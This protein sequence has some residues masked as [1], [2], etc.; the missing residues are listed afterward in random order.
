MEVNVRMMTIPQVARTGLLS[1]STL[2]KMDRQ[3][4]LPTIKVNKRVYVNY[5]KLVEMLNDLQGGSANG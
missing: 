4:Q 2:R 1:E 3:H 5:T